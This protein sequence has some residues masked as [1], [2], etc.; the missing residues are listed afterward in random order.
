MID[1]DDL[2]SRFQHHP[3]QNEFTVEAHETVRSALLET[4]ELLNKTIPD[5]REK[6]MA[7]TKL[8]EAMMWA[9][10]SIARNGI[11]VHPYISI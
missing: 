6:S 4:A 2:L 10:A 3:P 1:S 7:I 8:E 5:G 11:M 9:N